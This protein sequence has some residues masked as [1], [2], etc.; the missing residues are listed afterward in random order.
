M[1]YFVYMIENAKSR[2]YIGITTDPKRRL[3]EHNNSGA[4]STKPF[5]PWKLIYSEE[6]ENRSEACKRE[7]HLKNSV[8]KKEKSEIIEKFGNTN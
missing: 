6:F 8:G 4:K 1:K 7:W 5:G 2:H 3:A